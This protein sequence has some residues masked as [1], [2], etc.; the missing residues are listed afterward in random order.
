MKNTPSES[1]QCDANFWRLSL[2]ENPLV[3][4][5]ISVFP[6]QKIEGEV[7]EYASTITMVSSILEATVPAI[8]SLFLGPWSDKFGRRPILLSTFTGELKSSK[9]QHFLLKMIFFQ[10]ILQVLLF[11]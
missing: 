8:V 10:A 5:V 1:W 3:H 6:L 9:S 4:S 7:Q 2:L 11:L